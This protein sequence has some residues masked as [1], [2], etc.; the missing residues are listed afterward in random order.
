MSFALRVLTH[1]MAPIA[2]WAL[3]TP[4]VT[5]MLSDAMGFENQ[6]RRLQAAAEDPMEGRY[7]LFMIIGVAAGIVIPIIAW[8]VVGTSYK[9]QVTDQ[10]QP[11]PNPIPPNL[12]LADK[13]FK[14]PICA[15][16][17]DCSYCLH[18][19]CLEVVRISDTYHTVQAGAFWSVASAFLLTWILVQGISFGLQ[20]L[21]RDI[22]ADN[23][24]MRMQSSNFGN[25]A[26][27]IGNFFL[28]YYLAGL[29]SKLRTRFGDMNARGKFCQD[30]MLWW[31]CSCCVAIQEARQVDEAN[32]VRVECCCKLI[33]TMQQPQEVVGNTVVVG[34]V[35]A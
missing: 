32:N 30:W 10:R 25:A 20:M 34:Q 29:R 4:E 24:N 18:G 17:D 16:K 8:V 19:W 13:D 11:L 27:F 7:M 22:I 9:G 5:D 2:W 28:A 1:P 31:W 26:W 35:L 15:F 3:N 14:Y 6:A 12:S 23:R 21:V 33:K